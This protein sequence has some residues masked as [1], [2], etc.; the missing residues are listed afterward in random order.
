MS[1]IFPIVFPYRQE[2]G[3]L[4]ECYSFQ[5]IVSSFTLVIGLCIFLLGWTTT[6]FGEVSWLTILCVATVCILTLAEE[7]LRWRFP[8]PLK[9]GG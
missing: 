3:F 9:L 6:H 5:W 2:P 4:G 8:K 7:A 1:K